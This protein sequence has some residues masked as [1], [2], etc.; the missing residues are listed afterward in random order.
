M[1][2]REDT[3]VICAK[4]E[5]CMILAY[6][7][8]SADEKRE[9]VCSVASVVGSWPAWRLLEREWLIRTNGIPFHATD[10]ETNHGVYRNNSNAENKALYKDLATMVANSHLYGVGIAIDL[11]AMN[12]VFP[13]AEEIS[14]YRAFLEIMQVMTRAAKE[15]GEIADIT[16]DMRLDTVPNLAMLYGS[17]RENEPDWS[18]YLADELHFAYSRNQPRLQ[19]ADLIAYETMKALD[20]VVGPVKRPRRQ[21]M[22]VLEESDRFWTKAYSV[23]W[24]NGLKSQYSEVEKLAGFTLEHYWNWLDERKRQHSTSNLILFA[25]WM[26]KRKAQCKM[27]S[28]SLIA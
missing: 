1:L 19:V 6:G 25:D 8:D 22:K 27:N 4:V 3:G 10:C 20:N 11:K 7:D 2:L 5:R 17:V 16:F 21:S 28:K 9:R 23:D 13:G 18:P 24:F 12:D 15:G 14:Y 26:A